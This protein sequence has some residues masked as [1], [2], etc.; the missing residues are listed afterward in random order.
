[1]DSRRRWQ[2]PYHWVKKGYLGSLR[3]VLGWVSPIYILC[4]LGASTACQ[5][6][7]AILQCWPNVDPLLGFLGVN[8]IGLAEYF[9]LISATPLRLVMFCFLVPRSSRIEHKSLNFVSACAQSRPQLLILKRAKALLV[10]RG[11][12]ISRLRSPD[13]LIGCKLDNIL[14]RLELENRRKCRETEHSKKW[15]TVV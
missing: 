1:M 15:M 12:P 10:K 2:H 14:E 5:F 6:C 13:R 11:K 4:R 3:P 8:K 9:L 7:C